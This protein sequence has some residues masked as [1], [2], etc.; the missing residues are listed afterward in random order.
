MAADR[1]RGNQRPRFFLATIDEGIAVRD[2]EAM[3]ESRIS[4]VVPTRIK[5]IRPDYEAAVNVI[6]FEHFFQYHLDPA[7]ERW[8]AEGAVR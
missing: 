2:L 7:M 8:R 5:T 4:V 3:L 1:D 6:T